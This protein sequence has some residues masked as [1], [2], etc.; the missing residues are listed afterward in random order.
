MDEMLDFYDDKPTPICVNCRYDGEN[1]S[2]N[3]KERAKDIANNQERKNN[4]F[5]FCDYFE[6]K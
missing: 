6:P 1:F 3:C 5:D 2:C 4:T